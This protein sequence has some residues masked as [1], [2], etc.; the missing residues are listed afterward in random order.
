MVMQPRH[1]V[2]YRLESAEGG[3]DEVEVLR[4]LHD[5]RELRRVLD[6]ADAEYEAT[7]R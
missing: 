4:V 1:F 3:V 7:W 6:S 2:I 5:S